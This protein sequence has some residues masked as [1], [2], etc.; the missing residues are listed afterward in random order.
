MENIEKILLFK[1]NINTA[2]DVHTLQ[3]VLDTHPH[4]EKWSVDLDDQDKILRITSGKL[5]HNNIIDMIGLNGYRCEEL[6]D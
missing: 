4:I 3:T 6:K 5:C 1:T 2:A